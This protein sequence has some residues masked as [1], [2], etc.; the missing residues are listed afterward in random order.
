MRGSGSETSGTHSWCSKS[1]AS[2]VLCLSEIRDFLL[3]LKVT[4]ITMW[5]REMKPMQPCL[6]VSLR[7]GGMLPFRVLCA[8]KA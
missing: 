4:T 2:Q 7:H 6:L 3:H 1:T 5:L 8:V